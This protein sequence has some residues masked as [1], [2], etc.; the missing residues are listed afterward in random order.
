MEDTV[1]GQEKKREAVVRVNDR[2]AFTGNTYPEARQAGEAMIRE[3]QIDQPGQVVPYVEGD[4]GDSS[5]G[6]VTPPRDGSSWSGWH[7][8][9]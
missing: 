8:A 7:R 3:N 4:L 9:R 5:C 6:W 2:V 1:A